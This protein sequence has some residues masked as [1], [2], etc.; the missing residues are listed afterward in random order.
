M[1]KR[2]AIGASL[3]IALALYFAFRPRRKQETKSSPAASASAVDAPRPT[4]RARRS[5]LP[6]PAARNAAPSAPAEDPQGRTVFFAKWGGAPDELGRERPAEGNPQGPMSVGVD[7]KGRVTVLDA[8]N[9]RLVRR[10]PDG[11]PD[12]TF[13]LDVTNPEDVA[14][15]PDGSSAVLDRFRDK[16]VTLYDDSGRLRGKLSLEGDG[17]GDV[18]SV[19]GVFVDGNDVYVEREHATLVKLGDM[20][21]MA[22]EP[23]VEIPGRP[24]RDGL[25]YINAGIIEAATGRTWV[26]S[27]ERATMK[28]RF[29]RELHLGSFVRYVVL[30]DTDKLGTIY[31]AADVDQAGGGQGEQVVLTCLDPVSGEPVG[32]AVLP[33]NTLPEE[34]FRDLTVLDEG[35]VIQALRTDSGVTYAHYDCE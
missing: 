31:F 21:G 9:A 5:R 17:V 29:T 24:S 12:R 11:K 8:V 33:A 18:G 30:L 7:A 15:A 1:R 34:S 2:W 6:T 13:P 25:S 19:T 4:A 20:T 23:R 22:A 26:S 35:G 28:H 10:G 14:V 32:S 3:L 16:S 27:I